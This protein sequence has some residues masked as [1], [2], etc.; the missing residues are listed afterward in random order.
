MYEKC[1]VLLENIY[2][3]I[4]K[5]SVHF[6]YFSFKWKGVKPISMS[7]K[8]CRKWNFYLSQKKREEQKHNPTSK[9][10]L[11]LL[12]I[13]H[14]LLIITNY[15]FYQLWLPWRKIEKQKLVLNLNLVIVTSNELYFHSLHKRFKCIANRH[16]ELNICH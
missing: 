4:Q 11:K 14:W 15:H 13:F 1:W 8:I 6:Q 10:F 7:N 3:F 12:K 5:M 9:K 16:R 2:V